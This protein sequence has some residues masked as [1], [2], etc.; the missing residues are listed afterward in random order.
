MALRSTLKRRCLR[1]L[2]RGTTGPAGGDGSGYA[3]KVW[4]LAVAD[5][6]EEIEVRAEATLRAGEAERGLEVE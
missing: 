1:C 2:A 4:E 6:A 3:A 5:A